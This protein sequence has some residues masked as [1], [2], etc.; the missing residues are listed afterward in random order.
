MLI[1]PYWHIWQGIAIYL[2]M[3]KNE[4]FAFKKTLPLRIDNNN[5][6]YFENNTPY[7]TNRGM[8]VGLPEE[9]FI[10]RYNQFCIS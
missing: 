5:T 10:Y 4:F 1:K 9:L 6:V 2:K 8:C 3:N 7:F